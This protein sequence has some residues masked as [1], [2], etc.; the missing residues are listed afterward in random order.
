MLEEVRE[1]KPRVPVNVIA[2][3]HTPIVRFVGNDVDDDN[4]RCLLPWVKKVKIWQSEGKDVYFFC[5]RP[6]NKDAPWL[7]QQFIDLYNNDDP[8]LVLNN[9]SSK[10]N[11]S[12]ILCFDDEQLTL[13]LSI[14]F[15]R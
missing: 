1:K 2:T 11:Q 4:Q 14:F 5:H 6:D 3:G 7:A 13:S 8:S 15:N 10:A 9:L 12:R